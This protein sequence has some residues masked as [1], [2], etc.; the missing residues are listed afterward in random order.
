[1]ERITKWYEPKPMTNGK[2]GRVSN[3]EWLEFEKGR[4]LKK[5][6][7][8]SIRKHPRVPDLYALFV[9]NTKADVNDSN[10]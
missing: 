3:L 10:C 8:A 9:D 7:L 1:M 2:Y 5:G 4:F 6:K